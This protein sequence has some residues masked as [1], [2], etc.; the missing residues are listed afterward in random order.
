M[1]APAIIYTVGT[2]LF[3][4]SL[5]PLIQSDYWAFRVFEYPRLQKWLL[6]AATLVATVFF[7]DLSE[8]V[9]LGFAGALLINLVYL[10]YQVYPFLPVARIQVKAP[11]KADSARCLRIMIANVFQENI[12]TDKLVQM[13]VRQQPD[14]VVVSETNQTWVD[15]FRPLHE[16]YPYRVEVPQENTY[17]LVLLSRY[18]LHESQVHF[19]VEDDIPSIFA[20]VELPSGER[21]QFYCIH[22]TPP[23]PNENPR[24]TERDIEILLVGKMAKESTLPVVVAGDLNDVAWSYT[25]GLF[26][27]IS[28]L[29]D[30]RRGRGFFNTFHAKY[31][32]LRY[33]LDHIF[34]SEHWRL[35]AIRRLPYFGSDHFPMWVE[36]YYEPEVAAQQEKPQ[37]DA[38]DQQLAEEKIQEETRDE[39]AHKDS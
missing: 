9:P 11:T 28:G 23:V 39:K 3:L 21:V 17:G 32:F 37:A 38:E 5:M 35:G 27:K 4:A 1:I 30:P 29:L 22:P 13:I 25:T 12:H 2:F 26:Q 24:S 16:K 31:P 6:T 15:S 10:S 7:L 20:Q 36:L 34:C 18:E 19:L 33:P 14:V 8:Y